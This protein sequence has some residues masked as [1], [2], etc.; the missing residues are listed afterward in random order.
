MNL[1]RASRLQRPPWPQGLSGKQV[2]FSGLWQCCP[3]KPRGQV[4]TA[5]P[6]TCSPGE[7]GALQLPPLRQV[8]GRQGSVCW[9]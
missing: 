8:S 1:L 6:G 2:E 9:Q 4:Q 5:A 3:V 7:A